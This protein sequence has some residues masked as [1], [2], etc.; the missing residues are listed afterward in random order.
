MRYL[1]LRRV[2]K[3]V[4]VKFSLIYVNVSRVNILTFDK[5]LFK[6]HL[7]LVRQYL[8]DSFAITS[9]DAH[10]FLPLVSERA[11]KR[12]ENERCFSFSGARAPGQ[13]SLSG[14]VASIVKRYKG[15]EGRS[16][17]THADRARQRRGDKDMDN[18][19][20]SSVSVQTHLTY[21]FL[22]SPF[23]SSFPFFSSHVRELANSTSRYTGVQLY[24]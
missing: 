22:Y 4:T 23:P 17:K 15:S 11:T 16:K 1:Y 7:S 13:K 9:E 21:P 12:H 18:V 8:H 20:R 5:F 6:S 19:G 14:Y 24:R 10:R 3:L 2:I